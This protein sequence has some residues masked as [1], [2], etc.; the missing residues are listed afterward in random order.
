M[1]FEWDPEKAVR[2]HA[3]HGVTFAEAATAF[4]DP[5]SITIADPVHS[6]LEERFVLFGHSERG[7]L[8]AVAHVDR[9]GT[10][11]IISARLATRHER[12]QYES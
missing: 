8:L 5:L 4:G 9:D 11:R 1:Q 3:K 10:S 6:R 7:R 12:Q 2:N